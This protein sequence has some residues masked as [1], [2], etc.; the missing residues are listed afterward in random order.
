MP[1]SYVFS[2]PFL[3]ILSVT[4]IERE[5]DWYNQPRYVCRPKQDRSCLE[6]WFAKDATLITHRTLSHSCFSPSTEI[7]YS[8]SDR[9]IGSNNQELFHAWSVMHIITYP[10]AISGKAFEV[11]SLCVHSVLWATNPHPSKCLNALLSLSTYGN[12]KPRGTTFW[13]TGLKSVDTKL[14]WNHLRWQLL[15]QGRM[16]DLWL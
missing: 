11:R 16:T 13:D 14:P 12:P 6:F 4:K 5:R 2:S 1:S 10:T 15:M 8:Y 3:Q 9:H 7:I